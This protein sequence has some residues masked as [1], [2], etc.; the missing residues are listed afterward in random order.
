M[1]RRA[2][3]ALGP[4]LVGPG[5]LGACAA[6]APVAPPPGAAER[7]AA[8]D[9]SRAETIR[10]TLD[11]FAFDPAEIRLAIGRPVRIVFANSGVRAHDWTSPGFFAAV[12]LR[13]DATAAAVMAAGGSVEVPGG[14]E[15][16]LFVLPLV[17]GSHEVTCV[18]PLHTTLGMTGRV[19]VA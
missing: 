7:A 4:G 18:K 17:A 11:E 8:T 19:V 2:I 14:A 5:L 9:W 12:A 15:R 3:L 16:A 13:P 6:R 1:Q 10:V